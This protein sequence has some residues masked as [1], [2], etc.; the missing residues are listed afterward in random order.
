MMTPGALAHIND[1]AARSWQPPRAAAR[2]CP[3][4]PSSCH[5]A[6]V[7]IGHHVAGRSTRAPVRQ[8]DPAPCRRRPSRPP[9]LSGSAR[10]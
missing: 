1:A 7:H 8:G 2:G 3:E 5:T 10:R 4:Q 6:G 9:R